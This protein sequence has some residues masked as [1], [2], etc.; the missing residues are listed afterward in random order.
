MNKPGQH[1]EYIPTRDYYHRHQRAYFWEAAIG[2]PFGNHPL[3][4]Y[5]LGWV[6]PINFQLVKLLLPIHF[7]NITLKHNHVLQD[8]VLPLSKLRA[9]LEFSHKEVEVRVYMLRLT[10]IINKNPCVQLFFLS[11]SGTIY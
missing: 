1:I 4:R 2:L 3:F 9:A 11:G 8:F 7:M 6:F 10:N 5:T